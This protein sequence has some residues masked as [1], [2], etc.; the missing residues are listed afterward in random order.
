MPA[1][2][3]LVILAALVG[4]GFMTANLLQSPSI[5]SNQEVD[6]QVEKAQRLLAQYKGG[7]PGLLAALDRLSAAKPADAAAP[8]EPGSQPA[9]LAEEPADSEGTDYLAE[10]KSKLDNRR[11]ELDADLAKLGGEPAAPAAQFSSVQELHAAIKANGE[12]LNEALQAVQ[13]ATSAAAGSPQPVATRL[14]AIILYEKADLLRRQAAVYRAQLRTERAAFERLLTGINEADNLVQ[15]LGRELNGTAGGTANGAEVA[16]VPSIDEQIKALNTQGEE[17]KGQIADATKEVERITADV[18]DLKTKLAAARAKSEDAQK[19]M[20]EM[21]NAG[22]DAADPQATDR[23]AAEY[24][25][26]A[27]EERAAAR[28]A[29]LLQNGM[30]RNA[31]VDAQEENEILTAPLVPA[32]GGSVQPTLGLTARE[33]DLR[34]V[35]GQVA[36]YTAKQALIADQIKVLETRRGSLTADLA[37]AQTWKD[38]L[39]KQA[40]DHVQAGTAVADEAAKLENEALQVVTQGQTAASSAKQAASEWAQQVSE[41][42][43]ANQAASPQVGYLAA[44]AEAVTGDLELQRAWVLAQQAAGLQQLALMQSRLPGAKPAAAPTSQPDG[45]EPRTVETARKEA[46]TACDAALEAYKTAA[47]G[48]G[49]L[50]QLHTEMAAVHYLRSTLLTGDEAEKARA[51]ALKEYRAATR[52][53]GDKARDYQPMIQALTPQ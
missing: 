23:F 12:L 31:K 42:H 20:M 34:V 39:V 45:S 17:V 14:E 28:E 51:E 13:G 40:G 24:A 41:F 21:V 19:R 6:L 49:G 16:A 44:N 47:D 8:A 15:T 27:Q 50:W 53:Q 35:E 9:N 22:V 36:A 25:K 4:G 3:T 29:T 11:R 33:A 32:D 1:I 10:A 38:D 37:K 30:V 52:D 46:L 2:L 43:R 18:E 5:A 7:Q 26:V 48:L